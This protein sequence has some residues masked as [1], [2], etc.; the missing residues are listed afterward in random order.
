MSRRYQ[1][2]TIGPRSHEEFLLE[3]PDYVSDSQPLGVPW[4][5]SDYTDWPWG[6]IGAGVSL[7]I[8]IG[9]FYAFLNNTDEPHIL[10]FSLLAAN[11]APHF[12]AASNT[13]EHKRARFFGYLSPGEFHEERLPVNQQ[14]FEDDADSAAFPT[15]L[16]FVPK[17]PFLSLV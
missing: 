4:G 11:A 16:A 7:L 10:V 15:L 13:P 1:T 6:R 2:P 12:W 17:A 3:A 9:L 8:A 5:D 14:C